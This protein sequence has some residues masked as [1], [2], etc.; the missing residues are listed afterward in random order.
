MEKGLALLSLLCCVKEIP[1]KEIY[2]IGGKTKVLL[3]VQL[4]TNLSL[5]LGDLNATCG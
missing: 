5:L 2:D 3:F 4:M 1:P